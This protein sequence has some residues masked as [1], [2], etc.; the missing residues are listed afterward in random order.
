MTDNEIETISTTLNKLA[1][2]KITPKELLKAV[3]K[4]HPDASKKAIVR[5]A[6]YSIISNADS[7]PAKAERLQGFAI[8]ERA[9]GELE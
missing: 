2:P 3:R 1:T 6:F 4:H 9:S 5:A 8:G 7:D